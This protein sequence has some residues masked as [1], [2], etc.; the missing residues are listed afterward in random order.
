MRKGD[1]LLVTRIDR[2]ARS[3]LHL[4]AIAA[5]LER[6]GV[7]LEVIDQRIETATPSGRLHF[8]M[9]GAIA[10]F[11]TAL[12]KERQMEGI[13]RARSRGVHFGRSRRLTP[14]DVQDLHRLR[15]VGIPVV[16][17]TEVLQSKLDSV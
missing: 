13:A 15:A 14:Q 3:T 4:C 1:T 6:K 17:L 11:E 12:R 10:E 8:Q 7:A 16:E 5:T 9:L 2:L